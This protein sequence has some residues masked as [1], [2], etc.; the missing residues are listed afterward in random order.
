MNQPAR[1]ADVVNWK[2][3]LFQSTCLDSSDCDVCVC[4]VPKWWM[5]RTQFN[6]NVS[7]FRHQTRHTHKYLNHIF[8]FQMIQLCCQQRGVVQWVNSFSSARGVFIFRKHFNSSHDDGS[9]QQ[10]QS[11]LL[12]EW[13]MRFSF[14]HFKSAVS[15]SLWS[16]RKLFRHFTWP[17]TASHRFTFTLQTTSTV[18]FNFKTSSTNFL[19]S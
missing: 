14:I 10:F 4:A 9:S 8:T 5:G 19:F 6:D 3:D 2:L 12:I 7:Q 16:S 13:H 15:A 17:R 11:E 1:R 18:E